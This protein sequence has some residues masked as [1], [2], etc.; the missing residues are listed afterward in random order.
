MRAARQSHFLRLTALRPRGGCE[1][2]AVLVAALP[3]VSLGSAGKAGRWS[4]SLAPA[5]RGIAPAA[6]LLWSAL[7]WPGVGAASSGPWR[8]P[9]PPTPQLPLSR[10]GAKLHAPPA[11]GTTPVGGSREASLPNP[12]RQSHQAGA[13][14]GGRRDHEAARPPRTRALALSSL[15][16]PPQRRER[17]PV[18]PPTRHIGYEHLL[19]RA[20][21]D[22]RSRQ[23]GSCQRR[24][25]HVSKSLGRPPACRAPP[26]PLQGS[27]S[28]PAAGVSAGGGRASAR[29]PARGPCRRWRGPRRRLHELALS[30]GWSTALGVGTIP[31]PLSGGLRP[32]DA[33]RRRRN[34]SS[35]AGATIRVRC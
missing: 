26:T 6:A 15:R 12:R 5:Q 28:V 33:C 30:S 11:G 20:V 27:G 7:L 14:G 25:G 13:V 32:V 34:S 2:D 17:P 24:Q 23:R 16:G 31:P 19:R 9:S 18:G 3:G 8:A 22:D 1:G 21:R 29:G 4:L 10:A 35:K